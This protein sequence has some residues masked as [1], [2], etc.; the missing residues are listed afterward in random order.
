MSDMLRNN[1]LTDYLGDILY[2]RKPINQLIPDHP[3]FDTLPQME[4]LLAKDT[5]H[6]MLLSLSEA[7]AIVNE[8]T[9][10]ADNFFS[11]TLGAGNIKDIWD[12][13]NTSAKFST[14][15]NEAN[16]LSYNLNALGIKAISCR[17]GAETYIKITGYASTR[18]I[19]NGT[20][21][22]AT[23]PQI[24]ELG[25]GWRGMAYSITKG[26]KFCVYFSLAFRAIELIFK[27]EY[28]MVDFFG[29][30]IMDAAKTLISAVVV[31]AAGTLLAVF[32]APVLISLGIIIVIGIYLN[33][34][35]NSLD[36]E[37]GWSIAIKDMI[38]NALKENNKILQ[39]N[40]ANLFFEVNQILRAG[41]QNASN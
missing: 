12:G 7:R 9:G 23:N 25:I 6:I 29:D 3:Y 10:I 21:Y 2:G 31:G 41:I 15:L 27:S 16:V 26:V 24:L 32:G 13:I 18:R 11:Y 5:R 1:N 33:N 40:D 28:D 14:Y 8:L 19:L 20:R 39:W 30:V 22:L 35:L 34:K 17:Y 38:N 36:Q 4:A 37:H